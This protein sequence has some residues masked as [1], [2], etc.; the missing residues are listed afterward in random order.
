MD[1]APPPDSSEPPGEVSVCKVVLDDGVKQGITEGGWKVANGSV[2][3]EVEGSICKEVTGGVGNDSK[4]LLVRMTECED[5][6]ALSVG[7]IR[8]V[9]G[10]VVSLSYGRQS[11]PWCAIHLCC[12]E[13]YA[14]K[15]VYD[16]DGC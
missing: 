3:R 7:M 1:L 9:T 10:V 14:S 15:E 13:P 2:G 6:E 4:A 16:A 8:D 5:S 12:E 11:H